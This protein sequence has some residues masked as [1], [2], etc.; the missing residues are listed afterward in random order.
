MTTPQCVWQARCHLGE[1]PVW[2]EREQ[3]LYFVDIK[4]H[5]IHR[6]KPATDGRT[7]WVTPGPPGFVL[8][9]RGG[10]FVIGMGNKLAVWDPD[11]NAVTTRASIPN[12]PPGDRINDGYADTKGQLWFGTLNESNTMATGK[13]FRWNGR[14]SS[15]VT[16]DSGYV[17]TNGPVISPD[18]RTLYH[19]NSVEGAIYAF[20]VNAEGDLSAKRVFVQFE[21]NVFPDGMAMNE[22]GEIWVALFNGWRLD[23]ISPA[24]ERIDQIA[25]PCAQ[26]TKPAFGG[27]DLKT[28]YVTTA[29]LD[30][31]ADDKQAQPLAGG[32]FA[33]EVEKPGRVQGEVN[34]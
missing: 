2:I 26:V 30:F 1:G 8:P 7:S 5:A 3:A 15:I 28:L 12:H 10:G 13:L 32:L 17:V 29:Q 24:G 19:C 33:F 18:G 9:R 4:G 6:Y 27:K 23:L 31:S 25:L 20:D 14:E 21:P 16:C 34:A 11:T 22:R